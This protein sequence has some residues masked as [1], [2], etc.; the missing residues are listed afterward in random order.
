MSLATRKFISGSLS[1]LLLLAPCTGFLLAQAEEQTPLKGSVV[2]T[3]ENRQ[4][5]S[6]NPDDLKE[7]GGKS[8]NYLEM[9]VSTALTPGLTETGDEFFAKV[10]KDYTV[11]G[12]VVIPQ[13]TIVHGSVQQMQDPK[14][15]GR[16]GYISTKFDYMITPDGREIPIDGSHTTKD[17]KAKA[18]AKVVGR[19]AGFTLVGGVVGAVMVLKYGGMAAVA[20]SNGYA[21]AGGAAV[22]GAVGLTAA[23]LTK[24][25]NAMIQPGAELKVKLHEK[26]MLPTMNMPDPSANDLVLQG[27]QV[28]VIGAQIQDDPF[29]EAREITLSLD[30]TNKT[31]NT[32]SFFDMALVDEMGTAY[33][34]S[35]FGDTGMWFRKLEP[36]SHMRGNL[37]FN[38]D[39]P[40]LRYHLVF[41]KQYTREALA[42]I[43]ITPNMLAVTGKRKTSRTAQPNPQG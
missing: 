37:T 24:G 17:G 9:T 43:A 22:G 21:L 27:L 26:L 11:D 36:N 40:K 12:K 3:D 25:Q 39:N 38:V 5:P 4:N 31:S 23:M 8:G 18:I 6:I 30:L 1:A 34:P 2:I 41:Y 33:Y 32:F 7:V 13:D 28:Q 19:G 20:A 35:P 15:G 42:K 29:G 10:S 14:R 16:N